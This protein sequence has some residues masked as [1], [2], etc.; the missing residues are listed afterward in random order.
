MTRIRA[1]RLGT[2]SRRISSVSRHGRPFGHNTVKSMGRRLLRPQKILDDLEWILFEKSHLNVGQY[3]TNKQEH[4]SV[5]GASCDVFSAW[6]VKHNTQVA[7]KRIRAFMLEDKKLTKRL[8]REIRIWASLEHKNVLPFLGFFTEGDKKIPSLVSKWM[9]NGPLHKY[10]LTFPRCSSKTCELVR[11]QFVRNLIY[12]LD[13]TPSKLRGIAN[14]LEYLHAKEIVHA[15]LKSNNILIDSDG[16]PVLADFG[17]SITFNVSLMTTTGSVTGS[18]RWMAPELLLTSKHTKMSDVWAFGMVTYELLSWEIPY[19]EKERNPMVTLDI[20]RGDI[21][22]KPDIAGCDDDHMF[23]VIWKLCTMCW[24]NPTNRPSL[25]TIKR[26]LNVLDAPEED[27]NL[28]FPPLESL[29]YSE[30]L[31]RSSIR[32]DPNSFGVLAS[33]R[34]LEP[35]SHSSLLTN[36]TLG[37]PYIMSTAFNQWTTGDSNIF[38]TGADVGTSFATSSPGQS[39]NSTESR[40][41]SDIFTPP[42][43]YGVAA[44]GDGSSIV[45][46]PIDHPDISSQSRVHPAYLDYRTEQRHWSPMSIYD[47][48]P[49]PSIQ[50]GTWSPMSIFTVS[51]HEPLDSMPISWAPIC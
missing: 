3:I 18:T 10:M 20:F 8:A 29:E 49:T 7:V 17:L 27:L 50:S 9:M 35:D 13:L 43:T 4:P 34:S 14:G 48:S 16:T 42:S 30:V 25:W 51:P 21:P 26:H 22:T 31:L 11:S 36:Y 24:G 41:A 40:L 45:M 19:F 12:V 5:L 6:S 46:E 15:D 33:T 47:V 44:F 1:S 23:D 39:G 32:S 38:T 28:T 2:R 37:Y